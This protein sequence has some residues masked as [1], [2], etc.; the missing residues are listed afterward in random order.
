MYA[1]PLMVVSRRPAAGM[2]TMGSL[3]PNH[4]AERFAHLIVFI[5]ANSE[6]CPN[7]IFNAG[8]LGP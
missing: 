4:Q 2:R 5:S 6:L 1:T 8:Y 3:D 7:Q